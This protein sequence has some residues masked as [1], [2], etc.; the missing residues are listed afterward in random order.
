MQ[1]DST[2]ALISDSFRGA[3]IDNWP[4]KSTSYPASTTQPFLSLVCTRGPFLSGRT[5]KGPSSSSLSPSCEPAKGRVCDMEA[6]K[7]GETH[8]GLCC[9]PGTSSRRACLWLLCQW[10]WSWWVDCTD[11]NALCQWAIQMHWNRCRTPVN[12]QQQQQRMGDYRWIKMSPVS[13]AFICP[14]P[15]NVKDVIDCAVNS[16]VVVVTGHVEGTLKFNGPLLSKTKQKATVGGVT[17]SFF[18]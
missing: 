12:A 6:L 11:P 8:Q 2:S 3:L 18:P 14:P 5:G 15:L 10:S 13:P 16:H 1:W 9:L 4:W 7:Q 17:N